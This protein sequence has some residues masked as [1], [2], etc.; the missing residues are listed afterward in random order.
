MVDWYDDTIYP[1]HGPKG[2]PKVLRLKLKGLVITVH[3]RINKGDKWHLS[4][5]PTIFSSYPL[6]SISLEEAQN[7]AILKVCQKILSL[8]EA[9]K[10][11]TGQ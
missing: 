10:E 11:H 6:S 8:S 7:E 4:T 3:K 9:L 2:D 5:N 1:K